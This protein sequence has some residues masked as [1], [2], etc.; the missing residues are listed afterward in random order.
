MVTII[1]AVVLAAMSIATVVGAVALSRNATLDPRKD[2][3]LA[4]YLAARNYLATP[5]VDARPPSVGALY[6]DT[7]F[8]VA[9]RLSFALTVTT[10]QGQSTTTLFVVG[11]SAHAGTWFCVRRGTAASSR[12]AL[13][14]SHTLVSTNDALFDGQY[15]TYRMGNDGPPA[16]VRAR[17][18]AFPGCVETAGWTEGRMMVG[19]ET[20][21]ELNPARLDAA[22]ALAHEMAKG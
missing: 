20:T 8:G 3:A 18:L 19:I 1:I 5:R 17:V 16:S 7:V 2:Q 21:R 15:D 4:A 10:L 14:R 12:A 11:D 6:T 13:G 9:G 22:F